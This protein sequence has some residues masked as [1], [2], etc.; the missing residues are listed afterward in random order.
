MSG[1]G[2]EGQPLD[3]KSNQFARIL[4]IGPWSRSTPQGNIEDMATSTI[5]RLPEARERRIRHAVDIRRRMRPEPR[6][7][8]WIN[9]REVG[10]TRFPQLERS[11][12]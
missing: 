4:A 10:G 6:G 3:T 1:S 8:A 11:Y 5:T 9:G 7:R 12:D 2:P